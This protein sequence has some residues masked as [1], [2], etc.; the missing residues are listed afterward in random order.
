MQVVLPVMYDI[1]AETST[2][3]GYKTTLL[4]NYC[5]HVEW[6]ITKRYSKIIVE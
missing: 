1:N 4:G 5:K 3:K 6:E 2:E